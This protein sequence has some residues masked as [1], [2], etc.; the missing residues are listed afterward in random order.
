LVICLIL[1]RFRIG[2]IEA[3]LPFNGFCRGILG[4]FFIQ[5]IPLQQCFPRSLMKVANFAPVCLS[6]SEFFLFRTHYS[7]FYISV[8]VYMLMLGFEKKTQM[9]QEMGLCHDRS[10]AF[11]ALSILPWIAPCAFTVFQLRFN[12]MRAF[13]LG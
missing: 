3:I 11:E 12:E 5:L 6:L 13:Y 2:A 8:I 9:I 4:Y 7:V 1:S 10:P